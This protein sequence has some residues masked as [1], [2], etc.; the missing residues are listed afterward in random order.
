MQLEWPSTVWCGPLNVPTGRGGRILCRPSP[1]ATHVK[2]LLQCV[3]LFKV[4]KQLGWRHCLT[5]EP[6]A[7]RR[8]GGKKVVEEVSYVCGC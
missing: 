6:R 7:P 1:S 5:A 2:P 3:A 4:Q 8:T